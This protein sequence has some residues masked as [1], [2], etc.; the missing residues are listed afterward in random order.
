M[1]QRDEPKRVPLPWSLV[2]LVL[3]VG[4][5]LPAVVRVLTGLSFGASAALTGVVIV[6][7]LVLVARRVR[8]PT[9][10]QRNAALLGLMLGAIAAFMMFSPW[11]RG[12][13]CISG[14][15]DA[16]HHARNVLQFLDETPH[17]Y[18]DFVLLYG[19]VAWFRKL[20]HNGIYIGFAV[21]FYAL[22][23]VVVAC[24]GELAVL[25][26]A[27]GR[28]ARAQR[29]ALIVA[30]LV[31]AASAHGALLVQ[32]HYYH[33]EGFYP[34]IYALALLVLVWLADA[35]FPDG[36]LKVGVFLL[37]GALVRYTYGLNFPDLALAL[38]IILIT[39]RGSFRSV[40]RA[41]IAIA[42]AAV[43]VA[44]G[45]RAFSLIGEYYL[46][47]GPFIPYD[48][49]ALAGSEALL[50]LVLVPTLFG[51]EIARRRFRFPLVLAAINV[52]FFAVAKRPEEHLDYY[53]LK[54]SFQPFLL[55]LVAAGCATVHYVTRA[56]DEPRFR[57][58]GL[59]A[60]GVFAVALAA[61][62]YATRMWRDTYVARIA[63]RPPFFHMWPLVDFHAQLNIDNVLAKRKK[64]FGGYI[65]S[66]YPTMNFMNAAMGFWNGGIDFYYG[67]AP[68]DSAGHCVFW[69][70]GPAS[71][72]LEPD[73]P[74][75]GRVGALDRMRDKEC[76]TYRPTWEPAERRTICWH[77]Y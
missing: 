60:A 11:F 42:G 8:R 18:G 50:V 53:Y 22:V 67:K 30:P 33:A 5:G 12:T 61:G 70:S 54:T 35:T 41:F 73:Y 66:F 38:A 48:V 58:R 43:L 68:D 75:S 63:G 23:F 10:F 55:A 7:A 34:Q 21:A 15:P 4:S 62:S 59:T 46:K 71:S 74:Q 45:W 2:G 17:V 37:G 47:W 44:V 20:P 69:E 26:G 9:P 6:P 19:V 27:E 77:C 24:F 51:D 36:P 3:L 64:R 29:I 39:S 65:T 25:W 57:V 56:I 31:V 76:N 14:T 49:K 52:G 28:S 40:P 16:G 13:V 1:E 72:R 32:L